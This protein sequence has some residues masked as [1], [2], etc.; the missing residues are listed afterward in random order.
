MR[1]KDYT[2]QK[3]NKLTAIE[4]SHV[5]KNH[6]HWVFECECG[7]VK[8]LPAFKVAHGMTKSC[9]CLRE[10]HG[11]SDTRPHRI[12]SS[13]KR[14]CDNATYDEYK[15]Y[16]GR[17]ITYDEKWIT[18]NGFLE[19]MRDGYSDDLTL[20]RSNP[21]LGYTKGNCKWATRADQVRNRRKHSSNTSGVTGV[22]FSNEANAWVSGWYGVDGKGRNKYFSV[23]KYGEDQAFQLACDYRAEMI[24][25]LKTLGFNYTEFHGK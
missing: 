5:E 16:G 25:Q 14:R 24:S 13:M 18:F 9:G 22:W 6:A 12:W 1:R 3:F 4:F 8:T 21:S 15:Y 20:E 19:D 11:M 23:R 7:V 10:P 2:G 17:G